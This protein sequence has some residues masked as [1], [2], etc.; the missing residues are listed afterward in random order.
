MSETELAERL[1]RLE[2]NTRRL[3]GFCTAALVLAAALGAIAA[4]RPVPDK[5][6]AHEFDVVDSFGE[7]RVRLASQ[8]NSIPFV[9][10]YG[11]AQNS[12]VLSVGGVSS[13]NRSVRVG[14]WVVFHTSRGAPAI[15]MGIQADEPML[16]LTDR[17]GFGIALGNS[18]MVVP[19]TGETKHTSAASVVIFGN[20]KNHH[21]IWKAP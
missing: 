13:T 10:L 12:L 19:A 16:N 9:S 11:S 5:I 6:T 3:K 15:S 21:V 14:P 18:N 8:D 4:T 1:E 7:V 17:R 2:R 20:D